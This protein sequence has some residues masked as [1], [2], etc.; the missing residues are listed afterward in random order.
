MVEK[1][2]GQ[3]QLCTLWA[4]TMTDRQH[5]S[6]L[7]VDSFCGGVTQRFLSQWEHSSPAFLIPQLWHGSGD[8]YSNTWGAALFPA[9]LWEPQSQEEALLS[10]HWKLWSQHQSHTHQGDNGQHILREDLTGTCTKRA[11]TPN[12]RFMQATQGCS[13]VKSVLQDH[14]R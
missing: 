10:I 6:A 12:I 13:Y 8:F 5:Q 11:L 1:G 9:G 2:Q 14:S 3:F 4:H 7:P